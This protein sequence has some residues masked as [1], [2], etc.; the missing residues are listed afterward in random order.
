MD[1]HRPWGTVPNSIH[2]LNK[3]VHVRNSYD[4]EVLCSLQNLSGPGAFLSLNLAVV[5]DTSSLKNGMI[6]AFTA[7]IANVLAPTYDNDDKV[8]GSFYEE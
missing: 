3:S 8:K 4:Y 1:F 7:S 2:L 6:F 5:S